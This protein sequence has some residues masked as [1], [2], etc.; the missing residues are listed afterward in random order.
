MLRV[1]RRIAPP[2]IREVSCVPT[3][4]AMRP[5]PRVCAKV[6]AFLGG[7]VFALAVT[8]AMPRVVPHRPVGGSWDGVENEDRNV[9]IS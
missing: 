1:T 7:A 6:W 8:G 5:L 9:T 2:P 4:P 3:P